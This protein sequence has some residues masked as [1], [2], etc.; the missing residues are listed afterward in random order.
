[1]KEEDLKKYISWIDEYKSFSVIREDLLKQG[2]PAESIKDILQAID[3]FQSQKKL[4]KLNRTQGSQWIIA[5]II[6]GTV[7]LALFLSGSIP[8]MILSYS[9]FVSS[10]GMIV[11]GTRKRKEI[12][13]IEIKSYR[14]SFKERTGSNGMQNNPGIY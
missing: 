4:Q 9:G 7:S 5:G 8:F 13:I 1:L 2:V 3:D 12:P 11:Y 10:V 14:E 6:L